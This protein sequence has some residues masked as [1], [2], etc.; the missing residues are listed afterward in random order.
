MP[1]SLGIILWLQNGIYFF[2]QIFFIRQRLMSNNN[3]SDE[4][5]ALFYIH[6]IT[7]NSYIQVN[8]MHNVGISQSLKT[9]LVKRFQ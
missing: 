2:L 9:L 8:G 6:I 3:H 1:N 7:E 4:G 5:F